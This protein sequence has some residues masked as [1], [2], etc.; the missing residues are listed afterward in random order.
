MFL[1][2]GLGLGS[3]LVQALT[4]A[5]K[6]SYLA[7]GPASYPDLRLAVQSAPDLNMLQ[8]LAASVKGIERIFDRTT[9][10]TVFAPRDGAFDGLP[11]PFLNEVWKGGESLWPKVFWH[12]VA[13]GMADESA[14]REGRALQ[15]LSGETL[16]LGLAGGAL[17]VDG[18]PVVG[19]LRTPSSVVY[20]IDSLLVPP[21]GRER[22][23]AASSR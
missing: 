5:G 22:F 8:N 7:E 14:F 4:P 18:H 15:S 6:A 9:P 23:S 19:R 21:S 1:F 13:L 16:R 3:A 2:V 17:A 20:V 11:R 12:H 10:Y